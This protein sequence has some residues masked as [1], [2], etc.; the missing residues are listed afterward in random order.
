MS[1]SKIPERTRLLLWGKAGGRCEYDGCNEPLWLDSATKFE[2]NAA[3]IAH[4]VADKPSGPRGDLILSLKLRADL[5]NLM[6]LCDKHH[7]LIDHEQVKEHSVDCLCRMKE[8]HEQRVQFL[9]SLTENKQSHLLLYGANIGSH[10]SPV[11]W[12][13]TAPAVLPDYYPAEN[14]AI[15]LGMKNSS[16]ADN[17]PEYWRI[18]R[19]NLQNLFSHKVKSR[20]AAG[21]IN[22]LSVFALAP[23]PL[24]MELGHL[25]SDIPAVQVY[26]L[27]REPP[28]WKWQD[29]TEPIEFGVQKP[30]N[31]KQQAVALILALSATITV[32]RI[33]DILGKDV[34]IW[35]L[36]ISN[37]NN[38]FLKGRE[39]LSTF[40][41]SFRKL[42]DVIKAEHGQ[43]A[44][45]HVF[46]AVPVS[47]AVEIGRVRMPKADLPLR[48]Y[49]QNRGTGG[50]TF[51]FEIV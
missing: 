18:E 30:N 22:H 4:I 46:P 34:S 12:A 40:R 5:S 19:E 32:D 13:R 51:A 9:T 42:M 41:R 7:R 20:L 11:S 1:I 44:L 48:I 33:T 6:L 23:Q 17:S 10:S 35:T 8:Q 27:H 16:F 29:N 25:L 14:H 36:T 45:L 50:F 43:N 15:E 24:L 38:D 37:P 26:Q 47:V 2:F 28:N 31:S 39:H 21:D 49:D 3:Y